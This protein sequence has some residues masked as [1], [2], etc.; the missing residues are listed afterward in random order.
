MSGNTALVVDEPELPSAEPLPV[1]VLEVLEVL[2]EPSPVEV[3]SPELMSLGRVVTAGVVKPVEVASEVSPH[4]TRTKA[5]R[6]GVR[7]ALRA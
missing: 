2:D 5:A 6:I 7:I 1:E 3:D 4:A